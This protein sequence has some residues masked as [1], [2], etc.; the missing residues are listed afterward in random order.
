MPREVL[1]DYSEAKE[2]V[3]PASPKQ[4]RVQEQAGNLEE[5]RSWGRERERERLGLVAT[6]RIALLRVT[7]RQTGSTAGFCATVSFVTG[8]LQFLTKN[9]Y[10][11]SLPQ[12]ERTQH[13]RHCNQKK[14]QPCLRHFLFFPPTFL[15]CVRH[16]D[17]IE[18]LLACLRI[19]AGRLREDIP[20]RD[21][22]KLFDIC[23]L[24]KQYLKINSRKYTKY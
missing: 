2:Q 24:Y 13:S 9:M 19:V 22:L 18:D 23:T 20:L 5:D 8:H 12:T 17:V 6:Y 14:K 7:E 3:L 15:L 16:S 4:E 21:T 10:D 1:I 11:I